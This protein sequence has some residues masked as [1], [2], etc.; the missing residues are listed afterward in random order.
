[1]S[2]FWVFRILVADALVSRQTG[3]HTI[4]VTVTFSIEPTAGGVEGV[5]VD[6]I[7]PQQPGNG[8]GLFQHLQNGDI[9]AF[10][11][12]VEGKC[13]TDDPNGNGNGQG[14]LF[15]RA[16]ADLLIALASEL[17]LVP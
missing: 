9:E 15:T 14:K 2:S 16:E 17:L 13:C 6:I 4:T 3:G 1:M 8:N 12:Q 5:L 11:H 10:I 7:G